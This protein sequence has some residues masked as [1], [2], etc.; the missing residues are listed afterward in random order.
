MGVEDA[1]FFQ[2]QRESPSGVQPWLQGRGLSF[3]KVGKDREG[4]SHVLDSEGRYKD[5]VWEES[6]PTMKRETWG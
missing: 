3:S 1:L 5:V 2:P 6:R 4:P